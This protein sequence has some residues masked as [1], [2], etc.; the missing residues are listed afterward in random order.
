[1]LKLF[2]ICKKIPLFIFQ[3]YNEYLTDKNIENIYYLKQ[4][5]PEFIFYCFSEKECEYFIKNNF[6]IYIYNAYKSLIPFEYKRDLWKYCILYKY[7]GI[8]I[9]IDLIPNN[10][11]LIE[12]T[13]NNY[14]TLET[15]YYYN[16]KLIYTGFI[17]TRPNNILFLHAINNIID[18]ISNKYYGI[19][20]SYPTGSGL[21]TNINNTYNII[22]TTIDFNGKYIIYKYNRMNKIIFYNNI[23]NHSYKYLWNCKRIYNAKKLFFDIYI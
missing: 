2:G 21:L 15:D 13:S 20:A 18:N 10:F 17:I 5:N 23:N 6:S 8:Y 12:L 3:S 16:K 7:G 1:M 11:K 9:D 14:F 19:T 4:Y 22:K